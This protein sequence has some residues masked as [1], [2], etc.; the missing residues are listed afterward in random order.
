MKTNNDH[1]LMNI[2]E[3]QEVIFNQKQFPKILRILGYG[4][5]LLALLDIIEMLSHQIL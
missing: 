3:L 2:E 4:L 1:F 5:L